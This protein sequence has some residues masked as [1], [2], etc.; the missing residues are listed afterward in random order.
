MDN[1]KD[2]FHQ[3]MEATMSLHEAIRTGHSAL[4]QERSSLVFAKMVVRCANWARLAGYIDKVEFCELD[5]A[6]EILRQYN[7][8]LELLV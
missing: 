3:M 5:P 8:L 4:E 2:G 1:C 6:S 7:R